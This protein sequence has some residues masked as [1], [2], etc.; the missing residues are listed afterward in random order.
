[1]NKTMKE[2]RMLVVSK[3]LHQRLAALAQA[4]GRKMYWLTNDLLDK[5]IAVRSDGK[6]VADE[7]AQEEAR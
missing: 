6:L 5:A 2:R 1:M 4:E 7:R 3:E